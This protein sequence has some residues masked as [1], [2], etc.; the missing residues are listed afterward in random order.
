MR[1]AHIIKATGVAGAERHLLLLLPGLAARGLDIHLILLVTPRRAADPRHPMD[2]YA[3]AMADACPDNPIHV[4]KMTIRH[5]LD[6]GLTPALRG[7]LRQIEPDIVHSH[8]LH[9]DLFGLAAARSLRLR[10][11]P[12]LVMTRHN[13]DRFRRWPAFRLVNRALWG[14]VGAGIAISHSV[15][16]FCVGVEGAPP[17]KVHVIP[18]GMTPPEA[19]ID[20]AEASAALKAELG[21]PADALL[22]GMVCRLVEQKGVR[23]ALAA[24]AQ[25]LP[26]F[27]G[28]HLVIAGDGVQRAALERQARAL[29]ISRNVHFLGWRRDTDRVLAALDV[30]LMPSL[31][32]GFGLV[33]LEAM[34][35]RVPIIGSRVSAIPEVVQDG[36]TGRLVPPRDPAAL[37]E[38]LAELLGDTAL[39]RHMGLLGEDRLE[40][41]FSAETMIDKTLLVYEAVLRR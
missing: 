37:A 22:P 1:V 24:F 40:A 27:P 13:D 36:D 6:F 10:R 9:A 41:E 5:H 34:A 31:W 3:N 38:A 39:R 25:V 12:R 33:M 32:E 4:H 2:A 28:A 7:L 23:Y 30:L 35:Q 17:A 14:M 21:L 26:Q 29:G 16:R 18:Y 11:A 15:R 19:K 8:L 20:R